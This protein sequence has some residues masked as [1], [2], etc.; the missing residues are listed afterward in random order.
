MNGC[1]YTVT[2][3]QAQH[4]G[5]FLDKFLPAKVEPVKKGEPE[6]QREALR[7][8]AHARCD[9]GLY[10]RAFQ[11]WR[12]YW[13][14]QSETV[15][16]TEGVVRDRM[17]VGLGAESVLENGV[18]LQHTYGTPVIPG[19]TLKG[20]L[21]RALPPEHRNQRENERNVEWY[22]FGGTN[23]HG[24]VAFHDAWW[25]PDEKPPLALDVLTPHHQKY[26]DWEGPPTDFDNPVPVPFLCVRGSFLFVIGAPNASWREY[27][28]DLLKTALARDGVGAKRSSG[29]GVIDVK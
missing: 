13:Q 6:P 12:E 17:A 14:A 1:R 3:E 22:L 16:C 4:K 28:E 19:S 21:R 27:L 25:I 8:L 23:W 26:M 24:E 5:L 7:A 18:R 20:I 10:V 11:R 9:S 15:V 2:P 29:Y